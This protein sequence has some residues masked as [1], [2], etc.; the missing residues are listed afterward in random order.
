MKAFQYKGG[1]DSFIRMCETLKLKYES[2]NKYRYKDVYIEYAENIAMMT[3]GKGNS[4]GFEILKDDWLLIGT[5][6]KTN[7]CTDEFFKECFTHK[8][9]PWK[10]IKWKK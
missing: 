10:K 4:I 9:E 7:I 6:Y 1:Y 3:Y 8:G 2:I 5:T